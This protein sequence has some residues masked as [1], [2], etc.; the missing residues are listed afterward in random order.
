MVGKHEL[1]WEMVTFYLH[2]NNINKTVSIPLY[3]S[4]MF[5][6]GYHDVSTVI[7]KCFA[8]FYMYV[9]GVYWGN[10][11]KDVVIACNWSIEIGPCSTTYS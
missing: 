9:I 4:G 5:E 1:L 10:F 7:G 11:I 8:C 2:H 3:C 6:L